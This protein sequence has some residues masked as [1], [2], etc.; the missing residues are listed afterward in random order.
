MQITYEVQYAVLESSCD[1]SYSF[2]TDH[3]FDVTVTA[4]SPTHAQNMIIAQ[5]GGYEKCRVFSIREARWRE[6]D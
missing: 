2:R 1:A 6:R 4:A 3:V 5:N